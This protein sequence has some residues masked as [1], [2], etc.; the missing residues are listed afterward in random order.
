MFS[1]HNSACIRNVSVCGA[2]YEGPPAKRS[3]LRNY[4]GPSTKL[5]VLFPQKLGQRSYSDPNVYFVS[6]SSVNIYFNVFL[7]MLNSCLLITN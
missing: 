5:M 3:A 2:L 6:L 1:S 7:V 4:A